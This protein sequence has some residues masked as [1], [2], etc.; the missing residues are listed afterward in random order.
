MEATAQGILDLDGMNTFFGGIDLPFTNEGQLK[1][2]NGLIEADA[3]V[4]GAGS[5]IISNGGE[6]DIRHS[7]FAN[8]ISFSGAS[9]GTLGIMFGSWADSGTTGSFTGTLSGFAAGNLIDLYGFTFDAN[10]TLS[11]SPNHA[12]TGGTLSVTD[13]TYSTTIQL[14]GSYSP[15]G[16]QISSD[17]YE[18]FGGAKIT[19][20]PQLALAADLTNAE[21]LL[22]AGTAVNLNDNHLLVSDIAADLDP[23][24]LNAAN[25]YVLS[26]VGSYEFINPKNEIG[27]PNDVADL[28]QCV[29]LVEGLDHWTQVGTKYWKPNL[30]E[31]VDLGATAQNSIGQFNSALEGSIAIGTPIATFAEGKN[32]WHYTQEHA[33]IFLGYGTE[34]NSAG[35]AVPGF[36]VLDQWI[37][38]PPPTE[39]RTETAEVRFISFVTDHHAY[40]YFAIMV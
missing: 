30:N 31:Q 25:G 20:S 7:G 40:E 34:S 23:G 11:Y 14:A 35:V 27:V 39:P 29:A 4:N 21:A 10:S 28:N 17:G 1:A 6:L 15:A 24:G 38:Q 22:K 18:F 9:A 36:F 13:G 33:A 26:S 3:A 16:F 12:N 2:N 8:N 37:D 5:A 19:Y 32:G